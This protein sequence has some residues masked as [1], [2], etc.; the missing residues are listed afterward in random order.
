MKKSTPK[1]RQINS[2]RLVTACILAGILSVIVIIS[3]FVYYR[4]QI[5]ESSNILDNY[6][7]ENYDKH[8]V[9]I[10]S[11]FESYFWQNVYAKAKESA[12]IQGAYLEFLGTNLDV[13]YDETDLMKIAIQSQVDGIIVE[14]DDDEEMADLIGEA[15]DNGIPVVTVLG[16]CHGSKR[17]S[18]VGMGSYNLGQ[19]YGN[20]VWEILQED[21]EPKEKYQIVV[22]MDEGSYDTRQNLV[23]SGIQET[24]QEQYEGEAEISI[25]TS[26]INNRTAFAA[27]E[28]VRDIF[29]SEGMSPDIVI[30]L[31]E[32]Y[33]TCA[34]QAAIDYNK[35]GEVK[36]L[37]YYQSDT[38]LNGIDTDVIYAT[39]TMNTGQ[40]GDSCIAA[41]EEYGETGYVSDYIAVETSLINK[42]NVSEYIGR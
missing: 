8:Y 32:M 36:I 18:Y 6:N 27:E 39:L 23:Y 1:K 26:L 5:V 40:M 35:V 10:T 37:G 7:N 15:A 25:K 20:L 31:D 4:K 28:V 34:Y 22:L 30:C 11:D 2:T 42:K 41:L 24:I 33:T 21:K 29:L 14:A 3:S 38:I 16:D 13:E 9:M 12:G 19:E 17:I